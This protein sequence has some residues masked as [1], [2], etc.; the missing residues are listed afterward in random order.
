MLEAITIATVMVTSIAFVVTMEH[1]PVPTAAP[2]EG[3]DQKVRDILAIMNDTPT[4][5]ALGTN[6]LTVAIHECL[7]NDCSRLSDTIGD[8]LPT[9]ARYAVYLSTP[10]GLYPVYAP[11]DPPG[12]SVSARRVIEPGWS[13]QF[14]ATSQSIFNPLED[15]VVVYGL[16]V[17]SGAP[18]DQGGSPI[19]VT[20]EGQRVVDEA[21]YFLRGSTSTRAVDSDDQPV[22]PAVSVYFHDAG[23][24][25]ATLDATDDTIDIAGL[26]TGTPVRFH[27]RVKESGG[28]AIPTGAKLTIDVPHGWTASAPEADNAADWAILA[29]ATSGSG[30]AGNSSVIA[31]LTHGVSSGSVDLV[32]DAIYEGDADDHYAFHASLSTGVYARA[33]LLVRGDAHVAPS[34]Y[35]VPTLLISTP[36]PLGVAAT[37]TWTLAAFSP[38]P[39]RVTRIEIAEEEGRAIFDTV[40]PI[41][42]PVGS[43]ASTGD[44]LVWTGDVLLTQS[45]PLGLA[46]AVTSS[47]IGGPPTDRPSFVPSVRFGSDFEGQLFEQTSPGLHR[48]VFL[49][50]DGG[51]NGYDSSTGTALRQDHPAHS[52]A[53]YRTT[54]LP[55]SVNYTVGHA[56]GLKD[57]VFGSAIT[58]Q[59]RNVAPGGTATLSLELQSVMY[60]LATLGFT[61]SVDLYVYPPWAGNDRTPVRH[62]AVYN[63]TEDVGAGNFLDL[64]DLDGDNV[65]DAGNVGRYEIDVAIP[66]EWLH[67]AY[68][69]EAR[70]SWF[71]TLSEVIEGTPLT[72][73][74]FRS[75]NLYDYVVV[76]PDGQELSASPLYD[77]HLIAWLEEW[78]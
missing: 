17:Y 8:N 39:V 58:A 78:T 43:W 50:D 65:P 18:V 16:P 57:S 34:P 28:G 41:G 13:Y 7:Q 71:E 54:A 76:K 42:A 29:A 59:Q 11:D 63:G 19:R 67:G 30:N 12:E 37:T 72:E 69:L 64:V 14:L 38:D 70:V 66:E 44:K 1:A 52:S 4:S 75:A 35:E 20:L 47:A 32:F 9:G 46:F 10:Q 6:L 36:R 24:P 31:R 62:F 73:D 53:I 40:A 45:A 49:P 15:P 2:R 48:G 5:N 56:L 21:T 26:P 23:A 74:I 22:P 77:V 51:A 3:L 27:V 55:G 60:Q 33:Q 25:L 61:P 68:I